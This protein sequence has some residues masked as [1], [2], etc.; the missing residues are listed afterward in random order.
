MFEVK[1]SCIH[2]GLSA[3]TQSTGENR[4]WNSLRLP[5]IDIIVKE[6]TAYKSW[7]E[8]ASLVQY[9]ASLFQYYNL[10]IF[11]K[12]M[13]VFKY[14]NSSFGVFFHGLNNNKKQLDK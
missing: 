5:E 9:D 10:H 2:G 11:E 6:H 1:N 12:I 7:R 13:L 3:S 8:D 4:G 14:T